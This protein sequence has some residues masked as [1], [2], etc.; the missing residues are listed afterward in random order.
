MMSF[1]PNRTRS[2]LKR[3]VFAIAAVTLL[4]SAD[5]AAQ[6]KFYGEHEFRTSCAVCTRAGSVGSASRL[7][8]ASRASTHTPERPDT[9]ERRSATLSNPHWPNSGNRV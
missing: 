6:E 4:A 1:G 9:W 3:W 8:S 7:A 5:V 2:S